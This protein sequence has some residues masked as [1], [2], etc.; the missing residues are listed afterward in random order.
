MPE[1]LEVLLLTALVNRLV[2]VLT[3]PT[4]DITTP[5][6]PVA[7]PLAPYTPTTN[8]AYL[9]IRSLLTAESEG[10]GLGFNSSDIHR[11]IFQVDAVVPDNKGENPGLR[12][13]ALVAARFA[14]GTKLVAGS[15][16]VRIHRTPTI[17]APVKDAPWVRFPVSIPYFV[18]A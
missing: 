2:P 8:T 18:I 14:K 17:A 15:Y 11:G 10:V 4:S 6:T 1:P 7:L 5:A 13:A 9:D 16:R 12:L 3:T